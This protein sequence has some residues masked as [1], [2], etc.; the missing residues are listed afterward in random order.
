[1]RLTRELKT[2][3]ADDVVRLRGYVSPAFDGWGI[4]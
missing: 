1:V 4:A 2:R 3:L